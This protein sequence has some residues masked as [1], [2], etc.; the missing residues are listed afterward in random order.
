MVNFSMPC[1]VKKCTL[2]YKCLVKLAKVPIQDFLRQ[3]AKTLIRLHGFTSFTR[4][5]GYKTFFML[6]SAEHE[7]FSSNKYENANKLAFSYLL[8]K[9]SCSAIF[10]KKEFAIVSNLIFISMKNFMHS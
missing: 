8:E 10:S 6:N 4:P 2:R 5:R 9:F 3:T 1:N 7:I